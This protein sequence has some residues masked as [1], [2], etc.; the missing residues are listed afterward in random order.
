VYDGASSRTTVRGETRVTGAPPLPTREGVSARRCGATRTA[1]GA[2]G[3][4]RG[5]CDIRGCEGA[6]I[7]GEGDGAEARGA[8]ADWRGAD[9]VG[10]RSVGPPVVR[11][12]ARR[13]SSSRRECWANA[14]E[15]TLAVPTTA[16]RTLA[17][18][19]CDFFVPLGRPDN[20]FWY[21]A[22][23]RFRGT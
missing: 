2:L 12:G 13:L 5:C 4:L 8:G 15:A 1:G 6:D 9:P 20:I 14:G 21:M 11:E 3:R 18:R 22:L 7:R 10:G 17:I 19:A 23:A 16:S